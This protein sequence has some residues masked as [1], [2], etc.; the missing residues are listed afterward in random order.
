MRI[1]CNRCGQDSDAMTQP[2]MPGALG[3]EIREKI[4]PA[5]WREWL[6]AQ[7]MLINEYRINL[8]DPEARKTLEA[9]MRTFLKLSSA[10]PE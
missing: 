9:Q 7:V 4:C 2:P 5:C 10:H 6:G 3:G 1:V 8:M